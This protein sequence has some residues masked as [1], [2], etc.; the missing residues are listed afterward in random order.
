MFFKHYCSK[1]FFKKFSLE[2]IKNHPNAVRLYI[3]FDNYDP[4]IAVFKCLEPKASMIHF[5]QGT[6]K[7]KDGTWK[8]KVENTNKPG[9]KRKL[10]LL[11][12]F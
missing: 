12:E 5:W 10:S 8:Y 6:D 11:E 7:F 2:K 4:L 9:C 1:K 3:G